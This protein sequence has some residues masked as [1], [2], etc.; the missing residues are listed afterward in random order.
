MQKKVASTLKKTRLL[1]LTILGCFICY[2][3]LFLEP[4][5]FPIIFAFSICVSLFVF[6]LTTYFVKKKDSI[7]LSIFLFILLFINASIGFNWLNTLL[8]LSFV[9]GIRFLIQ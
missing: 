6:F 3:L 1:L 8:L 9:L 2:S 5:G 7:L 4:N